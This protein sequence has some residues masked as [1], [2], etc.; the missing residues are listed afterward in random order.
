MWNFL[1]AYILEYDKYQ[2]L[3]SYNVETPTYKIDNIK[4]NLKLI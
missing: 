3:N 2:N 4:L 1:K